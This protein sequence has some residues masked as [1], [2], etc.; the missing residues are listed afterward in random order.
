MN[1]SGSTLV[2][3]IYFITDRT[4]LTV[5]ACVITPNIC[6]NTTVGTF[7]SGSGNFAVL[8][9]NPNNSFLITVNSNDPFLIGLY[10]FSLAFTD[11]SGA[12][13][14]QSNTPIV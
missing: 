4:L 11:V 10:S 12:S 2:D 8:T 9:K 3:Q 5:Q 7:T 13:M 6:P 14:T 1:C